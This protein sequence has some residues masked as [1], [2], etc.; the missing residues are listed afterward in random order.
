[1]VHPQFFGF[2]ERVGIHFDNL[3]FQKGIDAIEETVRHAN[4]FFHAQAPWKMSQGEELSTILFLTYE[5]CRI[6]SVLLQ[7][8]VPDLANR[9]LSRLGMKPN[10]RHLKTA[11]LGG[12]PMMEIY[13][14][15][16]GKDNGVPLQRIAIKNLDTT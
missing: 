16:L 10:E 12:G 8:I 7:P 9:I 1:M 13:G 4:T 5:A 14:R 11:Q 2:P 3:A 6:S 15:P